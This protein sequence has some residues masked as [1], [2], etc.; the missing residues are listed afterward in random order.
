MDLGTTRQLEYEDLFTLPEQLEPI[1]CSKYLLESWDE[2]KKR[3][4][5]DRSFFHA[6]YL[7]YRWQYLL[8]GIVK[9]IVSVSVYLF[10]YYPYMCLFS[11][12]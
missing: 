9:V 11:F 10:Y 2:E 4:D 1:N 3:A 12:L 5:Q 7:V 6:I 8:I